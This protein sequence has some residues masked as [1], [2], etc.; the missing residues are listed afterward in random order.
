MG[1]SVWFFGGEPEIQRLICGRQCI[2]H[3]RDV[4]EIFKQS[5]HC[6][7]VKSKPQRGIFARSK[8]FGQYNRSPLAPTLFIGRLSQLAWT[9]TTKPI[10]IYNSCL[11]LCQYRLS[12]TSLGA[13]MNGRTLA[14]SSS[15]SPAWHIVSQWLDQTTQSEPWWTVVG[16]HLGTLAHE[17]QYNIEKQFEILLE[18]QAFGLWPLCPFARDIFGKV[19]AANFVKIGYYT[20]PYSILAISYIPYFLRFL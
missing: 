6:Y 17:S 3:V 19:L 16:P 9:I 4:A 11:Y 20:L 5:L 8:D 14:K 2:L 13:I 15:A 18:N 7:Y 10:D 12:Y 1:I